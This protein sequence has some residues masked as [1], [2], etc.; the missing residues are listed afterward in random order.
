MK[1][2]PDM[3]DEMSAS[4]PQDGDQ[5]FIGPFPTFVISG[6]TWFYRVQGE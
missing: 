6:A 3:P 5:L 4:W 1:G 2:E